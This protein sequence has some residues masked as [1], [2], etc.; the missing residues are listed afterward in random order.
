MCEA[1]FSA[2]CPPPPFLGLGFAPH[3]VR[4]KPT[5]AQGLF[6]GLGA[7]RFRGVRY[8]GKP[9]GA[10]KH[11]VESLARNAGEAREVT[12]MILEDLRV[13]HKLAS[14]WGSGLV[15]VDRKPQL[16]STKP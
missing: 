10:P 13:G 2:T 7:Q 14:V 6:K 8:L 9:P 12:A 4:A 15:G 3:K 16:P 1:R 5:A 11:L